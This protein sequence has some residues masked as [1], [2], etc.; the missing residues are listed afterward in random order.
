MERTDDD[1]GSD[2]H[3]DR[4]HARKTKVGEENL[5]VEYNGEG[6]F[7]EH[8]NHKQH[9]QCSSRI[10]VDRAIVQRYRVVSGLIWG[11]VVRSSLV[12]S[13]L[14]RGSFVG[15]SFVGSSFVGSSF[16]GSSFVGSSFVGS[17]FVSRSFVGQYFLRGGL[18]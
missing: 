17:S 1:P 8:R 13:G 18:L 4:L 7:E 12:C 15:S 3:Y 2:D 14:V 11:P 5:P 9:R 16:V 6:V 10:A